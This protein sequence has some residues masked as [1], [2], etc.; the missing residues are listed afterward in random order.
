MELLWGH[1]PREGCAQ[2]GEIPHAG[3]HT[4]AVGGTPYGGRDPNE[5]YAELAA[6]PH[7]GTSNGTVIR[8]GALWGHNPCDGCA[9]MGA[10]TPR[11]PATGAVG[12]A[13]YGARSV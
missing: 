10:A 3:A 13:P 2:L 11:E 12:G 7:A 8:W 6:G 1:D 4:G 9:D 5:K